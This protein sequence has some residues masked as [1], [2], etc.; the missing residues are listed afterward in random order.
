MQARRL[1]ALLTLAILAASACT[2]T[3]QQTV[4]QTLQDCDSCPALVRIPP[5]E[6]QVGLRDDEPLPP[7]V[8]P[9]RLAAER[10]AHTVRIDYPFAIGISEVTVAEFNEFAKDTAFEAKGCFVLQGAGWVFDKTADWRKPGFAVTDQYP[11]TCLSHDDFTAYLG[12]LSRKTGQTY[13]IPSEAEW[14]YVSR[15][16]LGDDP[17]PAT[18][19]ADACR[20]LN[21]ADQAFRRTLPADW[22]PGLLACDDGYPRASP[23]GSYPAN[24]LGMVDVFGNVAE[25]TAD[26]AGTNHDGAPIDGSARIAEPCSSHVLKGGS[27]SGGP[28]YQRPAVRNSFP[29]NLRG[30]G[31][32][33][34]VV[35]EL[36]TR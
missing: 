15:L 25:W 11:A 19:G 27:W 7:N 33:L 4:A 13:R 12:W 2:F 31:H 18:L 8:T 3:E 24:K 30:D 20:F 23:S 28:G 21:G 6:F 1:I 16:G 26:C 17:V 29:T 32:G 9:E 34:R 36:T 10:P 5:G 35:R 22:P 14:E